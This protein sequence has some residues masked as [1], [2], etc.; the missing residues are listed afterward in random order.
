[1]GFDRRI[2]RKIT[3]ALLHEPIPDAAVTLPLEVQG[4][5]PLRDFDCCAVFVVRRIL[6]DWGTAFCPFRVLKD[7][8]LHYDIGSDIPLEQLFK[9]SG[10]HYPHGCQYRAA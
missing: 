3:F 1:M 2:L 6:R 8:G 7:P 9:F 10:H 4:L 5:R